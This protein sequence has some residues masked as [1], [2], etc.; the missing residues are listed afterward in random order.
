MHPVIN[1]WLHY[2]LP[3]L[4]II[5]RGLFC[6][7]ILALSAS[8][9]YAVDQDRTQSIFKSVLALDS[10][11]KTAFIELEENPLSTAEAADYK[12][13]IVYLNTRIVAY[14]MELAEH[15]GTIALKDLPCPTLSV[16]SE[17]AGPPASPGEAVFYT[18]GSGTAAAR[19]RAEKT[20][21]L[22][23]D[24]FAALGDFDEML[25][26][27]EDRMAARVPSQRE[28]GTSRQT[29][30]RE[31][32]GALGETGETGSGEA[33]S[34]ESGTEGDAVADGR[35]AS[36]PDRSGTSAGIQSKSGAGDIAA[37][38]SRY[39]VPDGKLPPLKDDDIVARQLREAAE[40]EP[41]P[42][43]KRKL[44]EEYWKYTGV[45]KQGG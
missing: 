10:A 24:F 29:G 9:L 13:F 5:S 11:R 21:E 37:D 6:T 4:R 45:S 22:D 42:E 28:S 2:S 8:P 20:V 12:D 40:K 25:L 34:Q 31:N 19:T 17:V 14:C 27:E 35:P 30:T 33:G 44:W 16:R 32:D 38:H 7:A 3:I 15:S 26:K 36:Q 43:L 41:D 1:S 18:T 23:A 39:G